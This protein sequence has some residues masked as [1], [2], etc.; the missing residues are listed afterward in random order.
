MQDSLGYTDEIEKPSRNDSKLNAT[1]ESRNALAKK[2][3]LRVR[4]YWILE[5]KFCGRKRR[6]SRR[7]R[8][9]AK[10]FSLPRNNILLRRLPAQRRV[11]LPNGYVFF[12]NIK[13]TPT[14]TRVRIAKTYVRKIGSRRQRIKRIGP[15]NRQRRR[16][17]AGAGLDLSMAIDLDRKAAGSKLGKMMIN[18]VIDYIPTTYKKIKNKIT[19]KIVKALMNTGVDD[20]L[21]NRG[22]KLLGER[23]N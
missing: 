5:K 6:K 4:G 23:C 10:R 8:R 21:V 3:R 15:K 17:Q 9:R 1:T 20:Y 11:Q 18:D 12:A 22:V 16:Q 13:G 14:L 2:R 7:R 19:N